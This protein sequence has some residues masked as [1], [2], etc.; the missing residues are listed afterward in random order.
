MKEVCIVGRA[1]GFEKCL[2][3]PGE[4]WAVSTVFHQLPSDRVDWIFNLHQP[5]AMEGWLNDEAGRV[6][7]VYGP[8]QRFPAEYLLNKYGPVFG[9]S[10]A[11]MI[12]Y[13]LE[14]GYQRIYITGADMATHQEYIDQRDT[15]F[16][17]IGR[18]EAAG[19][20]VI[21]PP[22]SRLYFKDRIY[23]VM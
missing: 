17:W 14:E 1:P 22:D 4:I 12:A 23:G 19:I 11:W 10:I 6:I 21:I 16:Y 20:E 5:E 15:V 2:D 13:A 9:S 18:A 7:S 3:T 8:F